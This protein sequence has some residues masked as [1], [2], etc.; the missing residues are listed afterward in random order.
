M[1]AIFRHSL[2]IRP[3]ADQANDYAIGAEW[4]GEG[5]P[6]EPSAGGGVLSFIRKLLGHGPGR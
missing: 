2:G 5:P 4:D 6:M 3:H 1:D